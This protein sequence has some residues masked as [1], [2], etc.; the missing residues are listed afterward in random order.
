MALCRGRALWQSNNRP[1]QTLLSPD[2]LS[3]YTLYNFYNPF[4]FKLKCL[5]SISNENILAY[6]KLSIRKIFNKIEST[7]QPQTFPPLALCRGRARWQSNNRP[8]QALLSPALW[9]SN[10]RPGQ[11]LLSPDLLSI[12]TL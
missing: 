6:Y 8:G 5:S 2:S 10:N 4:V 7:G 12:Y 11:A 3:I 9:Q 1:G